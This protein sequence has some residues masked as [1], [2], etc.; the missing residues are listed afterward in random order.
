MSED[1]DDLRDRRLCCQCIREPYLSGMVVRD[2]VEAECWYCERSERTLAL[3]EIAALVDA[4]F[5]A[6]FY[7]TSPEPDSFQSAMHHDSESDYDWTQSG[8]PV[9]EAIGDAGRFPPAVAEDIAEI[10]ADDY[11]DFDM[12]AAGYQTEYSDQTQYEERGAKPDAWEAEW[13]AFE[14]SLKTA[15]RF[16]NQTAAAHLASVFEDLPALSTRDGRRVIVTAGP[17]APL[18]AL[19]RARVFQAEAP[20]L[21]ALK[22]PDVALGP[23][24]ARLAGGGRMNAAGIAV[25]YGASDVATAIAEVRPPVGSWVAVAQFEI[26]RPLRLLDLTALDKVILE[27]SVFD[28]TY[29]RRLERIMFLRTLSGRIS[30]AVMPDD[31]ALDYLATQAV[32]DYLA[33]D[34]ADLDGLL[35]PSVQAAGA[36]VN[37]VLFHKASRVE[38][39]ALPADAKV[40]ATNGDWYEEGFEIDYQVTVETKE[41]NPPPGGPTLPDPPPPRP[42]P[43]GAI[44]RDTRTPALRIQLDSVEVHDVARVTFETRLH[45][46]RRWS[47]KPWG[48]DPDDQRF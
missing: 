19:F 14:R 12:A 46:V 8:Q 2:G 39:I 7:R 10:L 1:L 38:P 16:F 3:G 44:G 5:Q 41:V 18:D 40:S 17:D 36:V 33:T 23:P 32:A 20:L 34:A 4:A 43:E 11:G 13:E 15:A 45:R 27:G 48:S 22:H 26:I 24:P 35:F 25:F 37:A 31:A 28:P 6:H 47:H 42:D 29:A 9:V 30:R 21:E